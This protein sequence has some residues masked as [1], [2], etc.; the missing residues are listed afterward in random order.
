MLDN[1]IEACQMCDRDRKIHL[2][3]RYHEGIVAI[4]CENS[5]KEKV[6]SM[7]TQKQDIENH[8]FGMMSMKHI[9]EKYNGM[10]AFDAEENWFVLK[11]SLHIVQ[12]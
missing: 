5:C 7:R 2:T 3:I 4:Q 9:V 11:I 1:A 8:G 6:V 10:I 12:N